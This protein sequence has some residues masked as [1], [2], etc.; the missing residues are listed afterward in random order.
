MDKPRMRALTCVL[1]L[2]L[3]ATVAR[4][5]A[6]ADFYRGKTV[7]LVLGYGPGGGYD[8]YARLIARFLGKYIPGEPNVV[9]V[10]MPGAGSLRGTNYLYNTA[11]RD[12]LTIGA[13][14]RD[15]TLMGVM[16]GNPAVQFDARKFNWLGSASSSAN[17]SYLLFVRADA[18]TNSIDA[19]RRPGGA[20]IVLAGTGEGATGNDVTVLVRDTLGL[21][22][23]IINGYP[24]SGAMFLAVDRKE[25]DGRFVGTSA[26][27][28]SKPD[29]LKPDSGMKVLLQFARATRHPDFPDAPT[30]REL[31]RDDRGRAL[32]ELAEL[33]YTLS[34][35]VAAPPGLPADRAR[36]LQDAFMAMQKDPAY[37]REAEKLGLD[38]SPVDGGEALR[39]IEKLSA[40]PPDLLDTLRKLQAT[41]K[42]G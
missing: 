39:L 1:L 30:A 36:A 23:K 33:P 37:L 5:D 8:V 26:V 20:P 22:L 40:S 35:P 12:G 11:P 2:V 17:D 19:A 18:A 31:A 28:S 25:V 27:R 3:S 14:A 41:N 9:V 32:I 10:N 24:D 7:Q 6:V 16:G 21:N 4:A 38:V 29:W 34:R 15:M 42:G 13:F